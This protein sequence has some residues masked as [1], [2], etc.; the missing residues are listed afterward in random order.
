MDDAGE[1]MS[2]LSSITFGPAIQ[3]QSLTSAPSRISTMQTSMPS[4]LVQSKRRTKSRV[5]HNTMAAMVLRTPREDLQWSASTPS[6]STGYWDYEKHTPAPQVRDDTWEPTTT[7][8]DDTSTSMGPIVEKSVRVARGHSTARFAVHQ[9]DEPGVS[10]LNAERPLTVR[11]SCH[12]HA[13]PS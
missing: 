3:H 9:E 11:M 13:A 10:R 12:L 5:P 8:D 7:D 4:V 2:F 6:S 1:D